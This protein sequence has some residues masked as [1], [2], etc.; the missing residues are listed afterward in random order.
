MKEFE[1]PVFKMIIHD[2]LIKEVKVKANQTL[3]EKDVWESRDLSDSYKPNAKF[4][5]LIEGEDN[6][7][8]SF[9]ARDAAASEEYSKN[10]AALA[11]HSK[12]PLDTIMGN[13][14]LKIKRPKVPTK[15]FEDRQKAME[16]LTELAN[17]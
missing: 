1:T 3:T 5:V 2:N 4:F 13:L 11:L 17:K 15:F 7:S 16:W 10:V 8:V 12:K 6:T 9:A 14:F